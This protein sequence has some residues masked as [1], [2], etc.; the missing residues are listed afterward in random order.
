MAGTIIANVSIRTNS[1]GS[2]GAFFMD[3][4]FVALNYKKNIIPLL[5]NPAG[6]L[7]YCYLE[8]SGS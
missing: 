5:I 2:K 3:L 4:N 6:M 7:S 1:L 8:Q